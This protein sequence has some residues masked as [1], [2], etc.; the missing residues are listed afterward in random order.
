MRN[1]KNLMS[2]RSGWRKEVPRLAEQQ[3]GVRVHTSP[4]GGGHNSGS[5]SSSSD[6]RALRE[7]AEAVSGGCISRRQRGC[8][9]SESEG[10]GPGILPKRQRLQDGSSPHPVSLDVGHDNRHGNTDNRARRGRGRGLVRTRHS[11]DNVTLG[12]SYNDDDDDNQSNASLNILAISS[13]SSG[14]DIDQDNRS[15]SPS[16]SASSMGSL[17][18]DSDLNFQAAPPALHYPKEASRQPTNS[19]QSTN[20]TVTPV[21]EAANGSRKQ[22]QTLTKG[23]INN[24]TTNNNFSPPPAFLQASQPILPSPPT[25]KPLPFCSAPLPPS[26]HPSADKQERMSTPP[27]P[28]T[29]LQIPLHRPAL[30]KYPS[31]SPQ[32]EWCAGSN[33]SLGPWGS[34]PSPAVSQSGFPR[35]P[36]PHLNYQQAPKQPPTFP[37]PPHA[38]G[39]DYRSGHLAPMATVVHS[40]GRTFSSSRAGVQGREFSSSASQA[41]HPRDFA[42]SGSSSS[43]QS[44]GFNPVSQ[45]REFTSPSAQMRQQSR[46]YKNAQPSKDFTSSGS[47]SQEHEYSN[48]AALGPNREFPSPSALK[49][50]QQ[51]REYANAQ[52]SR[53]FGNPNI[54]SQGREYPS[55]TTPTV[56]PRDAYSQ[57]QQNREYTNQNANTLARDFSSSNPQCQSHEFTN[58]TSPV[59]HRDFP[60]PS[61]LTQQQNKDYTN[62]S[63]AAQAKEL[64]SSQRSEY[65]GLEGQVSSRDFTHAGS[66]TQ[67]GREFIGFSSQNRDLTNPQ[68]P[69]DYPKNMEVSNPTSQIQ[70]RD[71]PS[72]NQQSQEFPSQTSQTAREFPNPSSQAVSQSFSNASTQ[73]QGHVS[74][75][76]PSRDFPSPVGPSQ[77]DFVSQKTRAI[78]NLN[79]SPGLL[80]LQ[81][82]NRDFANLDDHTVEFP[83]AQAA[84]SFHPPSTSSEFPSL[85][86]TQNKDNP[87]VLNQD[88]TG[89]LKDYSDFTSSQNQEF[90]NPKQSH[91]QEY[92]VP[93]SQPAPVLQPLSPSYTHP[94]SQRCSA[95]LPS[96]TSNLSPSPSSSSTSSSLT[97]IGQYRPS[98][99]QLSSNQNTPVV[100]IGDDER[101]VMVGGVF[102]PT[103]HASQ[104]THPTA[105]T[106]SC[107]E[108]LP[109]PPS[110]SVNHRQAFPQVPPC[111]YPASSTSASV[112]GSLLPSSAPLTLPLSGNA[113]PPN[114]SGYKPE[115]RT[116]LFPPSPSPPT[117]NYSPPALNP[118][119]SSVSQTP[120]HCLTPSSIINNNN[121]SS[122]INNSNINLALPP[123]NPCSRFLS[124]TPSTNSTPASLNPTTFHSN[125][126][127]AISKSLPPH[128]NSTNDPNSVSDH[129]SP[130]ASP[131]SSAALRPSSPTHPVSS[132]ALLSVTSSDLLPGLQATHIIKQEPNDKGVEE[133]ES[134]PPVLRS[135]SPEAKVVDIPIHA[136]QSARFHKVLDRGYNS[137]SRSDLYFVPLDD[138]KL[139][140]KR[141]DVAERTR[142]EVEQ[143]VRNEKERKHEREQGRER[144]RERDID[145][146]IQKDSRTAPGLLPFSTPH[147]TPAAQPSSTLP[148]LVEHTQSNM[149]CSPR[150][151][152]ALLLSPPPHPL[153][154]G[155]M[156]Q[157]CPMSQGSVAAVPPYLGPDMPA[158]RTLSEYARPHVMSPHQRPPSHLHHPYFVQFPNAHQD[159]AAAIL[160][161]IYG[162]LEGQVHP[163]ARDRVKPGFEFKTENISELAHLSAHTHAH[164]H[165]NS[166]AHHPSNSG[167]LLS[168]DTLCRRS[169]PLHHAFLHPSFSPLHPLPCSHTQAGARDPR[170]QPPVHPRIGGE[171][172]RGAA[173]GGRAGSSGGLQMVNV[174]PHHHQHSHIHSHLHLHQQDAALHAASAGVHPLIDPLN[175]G[176]HLSRL[177]YPAGELSNP[178]LTHPLHECEMLRQQ[179]FGI[180][181]R[182]LPPPSMPPQMSAAHQLQAMQA[183]SAELQRL[184]LEQQWIQHHSLPPTQ[185]DYYSHM[186]KENDKA[187]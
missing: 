54:Q 35:Y 173:P 119:S 5:S 48:L 86:P 53:E 175:S 23:N 150:S 187:L 126:N 84:Q 164:A 60:F 147:P 22:K 18:S 21:S 139:W 153:S 167:L 66:A 120:F 104:N 127:N 186:K 56:P 58:L 41:L 79:P 64:A 181:F 107:P 71:F 7:A 103:G 47:Q 121:T 74:T 98:P 162:G 182:E 55:L 130:A 141:S 165:T 31:L 122:A 29:S 85:P 148:I 172:E 154:R 132:H 94:A 78:P 11:R 90:P 25:L 99:A 178:L 67:P 87:S 125:S 157:L 174:T 24:N 151:G 6:S 96:L 106:T 10:E 62:P 109:P 142:R 46:D 68:L 185:E 12:T 57:Q 75:L 101:D 91:N 168:G 51:S 81:A 32:G 114:S 76:A 133:L 37:P 45:N 63:A 28:H 149:S 26:Q 111:L 77:L 8:D 72:L 92:L 61:A 123:L 73:L 34:S 30:L 110:V 16:L 136:S 171:S 13:C 170:E 42:A 65:P 105:A 38:P 83:S 80:S 49:Q 95:L 117:L 177:P 17:D 43:V 3:K 163:L 143:R 118:S 9:S 128:S 14:W 89:L 102:I 33:P 145:R 93:S 124:P 2:V 184:A 115:Y 50:K 152:S 27:A 44:C 112:P 137:C 146:S 158:L 15:S 135:T 180:Q 144:E 100:V 4:L 40:T 155:A 166:H 183:Q 179:L 97:P 113:S 59:A 160:G 176:P 134:P 39:R 70:P 88:F 1:N 161:F 19:T 69:K 36:I 156:E 159:M 138:S 169:L 131:A 140:K 116:A 108:D 129:P 82:P 20:Q 52:P